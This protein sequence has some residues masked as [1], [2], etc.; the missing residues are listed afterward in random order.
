MTDALDLLADALGDRYLIEEELGRGSSATVYRAQD[1]RHGRRVALKVLHSA[2]GAALGAERFQREIRTHARLHHPHILPLFDSGTAGDR[3]FYTMPYVEAGSLRDRLHRRGRLQ[4]E[5]VTRLADEVA[6]ALGYAHAHGVIHRDLKPENIMISPTGEA[7]LADFGIAYALESGADGQRGSGA[8]DRITETGVTVGTPAYMSPEQ[9]AGEERLDGRSDQYALAAVVYESLTGEVPFAGPNARAILAHKLTSVPRRLREAR[10]EIPQAVEQALSRALSRQADDRFES[11][12]GFSRALTTRPV[13]APR[14]LNHRRVVLMVG[15]LAIVGIGTLAGGLFRPSREVIG[16]GPATWEPDRVLVVLPF[17]NLGPPDDQYFADGLTEEIT[18]RLAGLSGLRVISR[19]SADQY[20]GSTKSLKEIGSELGASHVLEGSVRWER[21]PAERAGRI[22]VT[23]QLIQVTDDSHLWADSY[24]EELTEVFRIQSEIAERV[25]AALDV[26]LRAPER[27]ALASAGTRNAEAYDFYLRGNEYAARSYGRSFIEA[28]ANL[29]QKALAL[30]PNFALALARLSRAHSA[31]YWFNFDHTPA[32]LDSAKR[33]VDAA[34]RISPDLPEA[35]AALGYY[36]YWGSR[37]YGRGLD[38]FEAARRRQPSNSDILA[39]IGYVERRRGQWERAIE[40]LRE[41]VRYDP[42][43]QLLTLDLADTYMSARNYPEAERLFDRAIELAPE[44]AEPYAYKAMLYLTWK[45]DLIR[46][47]AVI[48]Q[49]LNRVS[50]GR[51][52]EA[53]MIPDAISASLL[54]SDSVFAASVDAVRPSAFDGDTAKYHLLLAEA[55]DFRGDTAGVRAHGDSA[56]VWFERTVRSQP[57]DA[58][59]LARLG[60]AYA[61]AGRK[62]DAIRTG[63][64]AAE[65]LP[66]SLDANS[67][68]MVATRLALIYAVVD[69]PERAIT[70]LAPLLSMPSWISPAELRSDPIWAPLRQHPRFAELLR[71]N[72]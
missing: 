34:L 49:A 70:T 24:E 51:L 48:G 29:Y 26:A 7:I 21:S 60:L 55:A 72:H 18:S 6:S 14:W 64:R 38:E 32:R 10:P 28:S 30:D 27:A 66:P 23:P 58:E 2:L 9:A 3:L 52:A 37:N 25:T 11:I 36:Y 46:A 17:K 22:R 4:L 57:A 71:S 59:L 35:R 12:E 68:P 62:A 15:L 65:M 53:L 61:R 5:E 54:T 42:R 39:A 13:P 1:L 67:G 20:R 56:R 63:L 44:L 19:T 41:A 45:G 16:T 47:R 33:A 69:E 40:R 43:S 8:G 31:M 50:A